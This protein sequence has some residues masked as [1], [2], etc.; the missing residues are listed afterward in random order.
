MLKHRFV[1]MVIIISLTLFGAYN[2][3]QIRFNFTLES[4]FLSDDPK[5]ADYERLVNLF[6]ESDNT[7][8]CAFRVD[9]LFT[10]QNLRHLDELTR[11]FKELPYIEKVQ[12][13]TDFMDIE[14]T[15]DGFSVQQLIQTLPKT[16]KGAQAIKNKVMNNPLVRDYL[17]S[18]DGNAAVIL[19]DI[20]ETYDDNEHRQEIFSKIRSFLPEYN[21]RLN[22]QIYLGGVPMVRNE[23]V[24]FSKRDNTIFPPLAAL[25]I[26]IL[27]ALV[28]RT[29]PGVLIPGSMI[30]IG[31]IWTVGLM[32]LTGSEINIVSTVLPTL[33]LVIG[34]AVAIHI[35]TQY[36]QTIEVGMSRRK[37]IV[38]TLS[39]VGIACFL[40]ALTTAI[41]FGSL[42]IS[43]VNMV[44]EFGIYAAAGAIFA[45]IISVTGV[46][47]SLSLCKIPSG[48]VKRKFERGLINKI[49]V[50]LGYY[51]TKHPWLVMM[52]GSIIIVLSMIGILRIKAEI[53]L[54]E[55]IKEHTYL[56]KGNVFM[57]ENLYGVVPI[58][59]LLTAENMDAF[60]EPQVLGALRR[61]QEKALQLPDVGRALS[62]VDLLMK[63]NSALHGD[64]VAYYRVPQSKEL[65]AQLI[66]L[67]EMSGEREI[68]TLVDESFR[69]ARIS[70]LINDIGSTKGD[71]LVDG[72]N[73]IINQELAGIEGIS[74]AIT[75]SS[76]LAWHIL[77]NM[78]KDLIKSLILA[79]FL[80]CILM[81]IV[82][83]SPK[84]GFISMIPNLIPIA[85][86][87]G[88]MGYAGIALKPSTSVIF[89]VALGLAV[90]DTIH[91][92]SR[93]REEFGRL[94]DHELAIKETMMTTGRA[95]MLTSVILIGGFI[96]LLFSEF[97]A[98]SIF[99]ALSMVVMASALV[100][101]LFLT[102]A[103]LILFKPRFPISNPKVKISSP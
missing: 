43:S 34:V 73:I 67:Y 54:F 55:D 30:V 70:L 61:I 82:F 80:I 24:R 35:M 101:D 10:P 29:L 46:P 23:Y 40:T 64:D 20:D 21:Q 51:T 36:Y 65:A 18:R 66:L 31:L 96:L 83:R 38:R 12:S 92:L 15:D 6:G 3:V 103:C 41:G 76:V 53:R 87:M 33:I 99:G 47:V 1:Y 9:E 100:G 22:T 13:L 94:G 58:E 8:L 68:F 71:E 90:D 45:F 63:M 79:I 60:K 5:K 44:R 50:F 27:L 81:T 28:Y 25:F 78:V 98:T 77:L 57:E 2:A 75:G 89:C 42:A 17:V 84:I 37:I 102:P 97:D 19:A 39:L 11:A 62:M 52:I 7:I 86:A 16:K 72:L 32:A 56:Y 49:L 93:F 91:F 85:I 74:Y 14:G 4:F 26:S 95:I 48:K 59:I 69:N 88:I